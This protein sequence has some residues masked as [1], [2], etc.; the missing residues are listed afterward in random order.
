MTK[1]Y[2]VMTMNAL[3]KTILITVGAATFTSILCTVLLRTL[4]SEP[5]WKSSG[6]GRTIF[7]TRTG[8]LRYT[9][10]GRIVAE[11]QADRDRETK[12]SAIR[13]E[14]ERLADKRNRELVR[15]HN[16][17]IFRKLKR[18]VDANPA[19]N[20][21]HIY[22]EFQWMLNTKPFRTNKLL[23]RRQHETL[24]D[25]LGRAIRKEPYKSNPEFSQAIKDLN[26][27][28]MNYTNF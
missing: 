6:D 18:F 21:D 3:N 15:N 16:S 1:R 23:S 22:D 17:A 12:L 7:S 11:V 20:V 4:W 5:E 9:S 24:L 10:S 25:F 13:L 14:S 8:E 26:E 19:V 27:W 2:E 28:D